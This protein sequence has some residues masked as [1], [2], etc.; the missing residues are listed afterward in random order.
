L[1]E[2]GTTRGSGWVRSPVTTRLTRSKF[3]P[4]VG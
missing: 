1:D 2:V 3:D 4:L